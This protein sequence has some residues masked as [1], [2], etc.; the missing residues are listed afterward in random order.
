M[1]GYFVYIAFMIQLIEV[2]ILVTTTKISSNFEVMWS[3]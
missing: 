3:I 1:A 2:F